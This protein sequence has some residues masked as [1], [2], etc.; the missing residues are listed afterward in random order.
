MLHDFLEKNIQNK[1]NILYVIHARK[2]TTRKEL[3]ELLH[4]SVSGINSLISEIN[5]EIKEL[6]TISKNS[7]YLYITFHKDTDISSLIHLICQNSD[8]L[9]CLK[10]FITNDDKQPFVSFYEQNFLTQSSA[11][12]IRNA[13]HKYLLSVGLDLSQNKVCG[14]EYRIRFLIS[15]LYYKYGI[16]CCGFDTDSIY[17]TRNFILKTNQTISIEYLNRVST[18]LG[19]FECLF[20]LSW[21]RKQ[22]PVKIPYFNYFDKLKELFIYK[23]MK[24]M[25]KSSLE[26]ILNINFSED[27][28]DYLYLVY[29]CTNNCLFAD[30]WTQQDIVQTHSTVFS[31]NIFN[32][33]VRK[34]QN[35][36]SK[37]IHISHPFKATLIYFYKKCLLELSCLIPDE[38]FYV[39]SKRNETTQVIYKLLSNVL[40]DWRKSNHL[41]FEIDKSH[42]FY[43]SLQFEFILYQRTMPVPIYILSDLNAELEV[44]TLYL[45]NHFSSRSALV[46]P[47]LINVQ[48]IEFLYFQK[49]CIIITPK[50]FEYFLASKIST[51]HNTFIPIS[52]EINSHELNDINNAFEH[53]KKI[54]FLDYIN[55]LL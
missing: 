52:I 15:L 20:M 50:K 31:D 18:E 26:P 46:T 19:Y 39:Y 27:D 48:N 21:K 4:L 51:E 28:Y 43:L 16:D 37:D 47:L 8:I 49:N 17:I 24:T 38:H 29:C 53:Y 22:Y 54:Y 9:H 13:C 32:D 44:M 40:Q 3:N 14:E 36:F 45:N 1:L 6:A 33:L 35:V 11:Y 2:F 34:F 7:S 23:E 42:I 10:F 25:L 55:S 41:K 5:I 12:R 30:K